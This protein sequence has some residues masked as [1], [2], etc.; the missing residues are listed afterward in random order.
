MQ[1]TQKVQ[2]T[3]QTREAALAPKPIALCPCPQ[4]GTQRCNRLQLK[5]NQR[6]PGLLRARQNNTQT[7]SKQKTDNG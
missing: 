6:A 4:T 1:A 2:L 7:N 3:F 5:I